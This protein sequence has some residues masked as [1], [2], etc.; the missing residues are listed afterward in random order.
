M[1]RMGEILVSGNKNQSDDRHPLRMKD[2]EP[3]SLG[4]LTHW[5]IMWMH[6]GGVN[7]G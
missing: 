2:I 1:L 6:F 7:N 3:L 4:K 5:G